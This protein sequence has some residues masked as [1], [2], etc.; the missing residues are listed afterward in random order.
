MPTIEATCLAN[1]RM[2]SNLAEHAVHSTVLG[3]SRPPWPTGLCIMMTPTMSST[4]ASSGTIIS[5]LDAICLSVSLILRVI[6][7]LRPI[8][9]TQYITDP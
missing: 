1:P 4:I 5:C 2:S 6:Y 3:V 7:V 8:H 9:V